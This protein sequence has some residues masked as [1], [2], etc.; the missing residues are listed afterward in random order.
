[1]PAVRVTTLPVLV[2]ALAG[3][4]AP[5]AADARGAAHL[6]VKANSTASDQEVGAA[7]TATSEPGATCSGVVAVGRTH[8]SL[9]ATKL[10]SSGAVKWSWR[11]NA[12]VRAG[13]WTATVTCR[14]SRGAYDTQVKRFPAVAGLGAGAG[15]QLFVPHSLVVTRPPTKKK[16][17]GEAG[18]SLYPQGQ[19]TWWVALLRPDLPWFPGQEGN[20]LNWA[21]AARKRGIPTGAAPA[22]GAVAVFAP[23]QDGA[24][25]YG[26]VAYVTAVEPGEMITI[27]EY[28]FEDK[29]E[30]HVRTI[31]A[32]GLTFIYQRAATKP[33]THESKPEEKGPPEKAISPIA[34]TYPETTGGVVKTWTNYLN[35]GGTEGEA[36]PAEHTVQV[37][38]RISG[39]RV[40]DGDTWWYRIA[41]S[42][43]SGSF[44]ASADPFYNDGATSG[45]LVG[46]PPVDP[47]VPEC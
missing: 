6:V 44:Y 31:P 46:T 29:P 39:F 24:G 27:S 19:C 21:A 18:A 45:G 23:G 11:I 36:I 17:T 16:G 22:V 7:V 35:A 2:A 34:R 14:L 26:H 13:E 38:C 25:E 3:L 28:N 30:K 10:G 4:A 43:W 9:P 5:V 32:A 37:Y 15:S 47:T 8:R 20:A 33:G 40:E 12:A 42:P 1:M 41:S